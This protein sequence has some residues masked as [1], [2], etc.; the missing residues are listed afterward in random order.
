MP[1]A[2][3]N[4]VSI[5][6]FKEPTDYLCT[7][8]CSTAFQSLQPITTQPS[9]H[10]HSWLY[11]A[12]IGNRFPV[13]IL[14]SQLKYCAVG[15]VSLDIFLPIARVGSWRIQTVILMQHTAASRI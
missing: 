10:P 2:D 14:D 6:R 15:Q 1:P 5:Y 12:H 9:R 8:Q 7:I 11:R 3:P 13:W 4:V